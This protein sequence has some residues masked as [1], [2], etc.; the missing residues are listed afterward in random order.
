MTA[1][2]H[3]AGRKAAAFGQA[4]LVH[5]AFGFVLVYGLSTSEIRIQPRNPTIQATVVD[6]S[7][8][9]AARQAA[10]QRE[11]ERLRDEARQR[12]AAEA[13]RQRQAEA[14]RQ[15]RAAEQAEQ[16]RI[17]AER[18][19]VEQRRQAQRER[20]REL[21]AERERQLEDIRRQRQEA[22]DERRRLEAEQE[23][24]DEARRE[25]EDARQRELEEQRRQQLLDLEQQQQTQAAQ[26]T[27]EQ[28]W[29]GAIQALVTQNWRRPPSARRGVVCMVRVDQ[30]PGGDVVSAVVLPGCRAD[31]ITRR[32]IIDAVMRSEP[33]P[34]RGFESV[35]R[36]QLTFEFLIDE[37]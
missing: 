7:Q 32:S 16:D 20:E 13:E 27:L 36:R 11:T 24:L 4:V 31:E 29:V 12:R 26:A 37:D 21:A 10:Q 33:L 15:Q 35:F 8:I 22:E 19:A 34:Y 17:A 14:E 30:L 6:R 28:Q 2:V 23:R 25:Q 3:D 5:V 18:L 1:A 9:L